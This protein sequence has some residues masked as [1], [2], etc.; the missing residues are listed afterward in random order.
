MNRSKKRKHH[1]SMIEQRKAM[2]MKLKKPGNSE[3]KRE[4]IKEFLIYVLWTWLS[5]FKREGGVSV[6]GMTIMATLI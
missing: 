1:K 2:I 5:F 3:G 4:W 6:Y